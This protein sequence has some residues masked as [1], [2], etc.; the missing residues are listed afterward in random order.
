MHGLVVDAGDRALHKFALVALQ[1][2]LVRVVQLVGKLCVDEGQWQ[3]HAVEESRAAVD[4]HDVEAGLCE[5]RHGADAGIAEANDG[6]DRALHR[7][8]ASR[9][10]RRHCVQAGATTGLPPATHNR[11]LKECRSTNEMAS[12]C[13]SVLTKVNQRGSV[14]T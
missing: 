7:R 4:A 1:Q 9:S 5:E 10:C 12:R 3:C 11:V 8:R 13:C 6:D 14:Y 2:P